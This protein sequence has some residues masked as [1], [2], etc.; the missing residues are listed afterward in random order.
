[1]KTYHLIGQLVDPDG[2]FYGVILVHQLSHIQSACFPTNYAWLSNCLATGKIVF[3]RYFA[4]DWSISHCSVAVVGWLPP[5]HFGADHWRD[6]RDW[7]GS[8]IPIKGLFN[9]L[10]GNNNRSLLIVWYLMLLRAM[11]LIWNYVNNN[12]HFYTIRLD[13]VPS[14]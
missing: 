13:C 6:W 7:G 1:M 9:D 4:I 3:H 5:F 8:L 2:I 12:N 11:M 14:V 10:G